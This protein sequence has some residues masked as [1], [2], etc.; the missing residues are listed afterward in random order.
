MSREN[1]TPP[2]GESVNGFRSVEIAPSCYRVFCSIAGIAPDWEK[3]DQSIWDRMCCQA[4]RAV[5]QMI[6]T[7]QAISFQQLAKAISIWAG[8]PPESWEGLTPVWKTAWE[9]VGRHIVNCLDAEPGGVNVEEIEPKY[10]EW[11][12][13]RLSQLQPQGAS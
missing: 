1:K 10:K 3:E 4:F 12:N 9:A 11:A 8:M 13:R 6:E 2:L 5:D 7:E